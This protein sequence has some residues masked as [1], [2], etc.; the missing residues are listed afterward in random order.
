M[1]EE[2]EESGAASLL[3]ASGMESRFSRVSKTH[4]TSETLPSVQGNT[5]ISEGDVGI[6][7]ELEMMSMAEKGEDCDAEIDV[8]YFSRGDTPSPA[9]SVSLPSSYYAHSALTR[10]PIAVERNNSWTRGTGK[11]LSRNASAICHLGI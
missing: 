4:S 5:E 7:E 10:W 11:V 8:S 1:D 3:H 9:P 6:D 2:D